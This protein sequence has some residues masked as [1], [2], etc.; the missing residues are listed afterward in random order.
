MGEA[1]DFML[2][3]FERQTIWIMQSNDGGFRIMIQRASNALIV[4]TLGPERRRARWNGEGHG[5]CLAKA[6]LSCA[7]IFPREE[8]DQRA[9]RASRVAV[10]EMP[11]RSIIK[12]DGLFDE[13]QSEH[14]RVE[15]M[16]AAD[17]ARQSGDVMEADGLCH[18]P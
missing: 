16:R 8:S 12:I 10:I 4:E 6:R 5:Y 1:Q 13:P 9:G 15:I 7:R 2:D 11:A 17:V 3:Q 18:G 14:A